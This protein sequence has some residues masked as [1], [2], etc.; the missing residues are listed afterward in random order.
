MTC[1]VGI[2]DRG[3]VYIGGDSAG[4][5]GH[6]LRTDVR[7]DEKVFILDKRFIIG[8]TTSF[9]MGQIL[10]YSFDPPEHPRNVSDIRYLSTLF[11]DAMRASFNSKGYVQRTEGGQ[12]SGGT[13]L[14]GY[15]GKLYVIYDDFQIAKNKLP[16]AAVGCGEELALG[17]MFT[18]EGER[19]AEKRIHTALDAA[20]KFSGGVLPPF[21]VLRL[22]K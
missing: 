10:R 11:V 3:S 5:D 9:R 7:S 12:E 22:K 8:Y 17:S 16:Y 21:T 2:E 15:R 20:V 1:I 14:L 4:V 13:F 18:S 6:S 19:S